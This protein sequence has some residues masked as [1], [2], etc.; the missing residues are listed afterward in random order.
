MISLSSY[1]REWTRNVKGDLLSGLVVA[2]ALIPEAI[3]FSIIAGVDPKVGLYASFSIAVITAIV[4][5]RPG[6]ISAATAATAV[7]MVTLVKEHGL[8]YLLA[9]TILAGVLQVGAGLLRLG[10]VMR[11]V[12]RSVMTGFVNALAILIFMAQ[13]PEL[14]NVPPLTYVMVAAGLGII[15]LFPL[16]TKAVPSPL[17]C[18]VI[19]T[20]VS[21]S[22]GL[23]LRTVGDMGELPDTLPIFLLPD[24]PLTLETLMIILP[25]SAAVAAVGLLESLMTQNLVDELTDTTS[26]KNQECV[27]QGVAN[28]CTGFI[29]GM[30]GCAMIGQS[31]INVKSGGRGRLSTFVAGA[32]LLVLV[33]FL[34]DFVARIPMA[35][36]VAIMIMV[37]V[38]TFSWSSLKNLRDHPPSSSIVMVATV[39]FVVFTHNLAIGVL[40][41]VLLSGIFFAW[42]IAQLFG[43]RSELSE[44]GRA[45]RYIVEGQLFFASSEDFM[46]AFDFREALEKVQI[47]VSRAHIWDI[48]S[49]AALDMAVLKFRREGAEVEI[50]GMNEAS[51]TI[52]D[53]LGEHDK[54]GAMDKLLA[55]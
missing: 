6:M 38:G 29:G 7:L 14:I 52:V 39:V 26:S 27:G 21:L 30:A 45:R 22:L 31:M 5:G 18:I 37:S 44:D 47:D 11:F 55:H 48:S 1:G 19:L 8:Q 40:V 9:A 41:G 35:A 15:Y 24:I 4:G 13:L 51:R 28:F 20:T 17:I 49:V 23:D 46:K 2:L 25:Y 50:I 32:V 16:L 53:R 36:L 33:V 42:K 43:V 10:Y 3:A 12:S 34:G 54:P